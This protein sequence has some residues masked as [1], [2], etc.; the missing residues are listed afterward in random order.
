MAHSS[1]PPVI[2]IMRMAFATL[3]VI[4]PPLAVTWAYKIWFQSPRYKT[5]KRELAWLSQ[6]RQIQINSS[7]G[8]IATY[9]WGDASKPRVFL[10]HGWSGR[11]LQL[12]AFVEP[13]LQAGYSVTS[14]DAPGHG[15]SDGNSTT[16]F[17]VADVLRQIVLDA[18]RPH[19]IISH[20]FG[21]M[22]SAYALHH[23]QLDIHKCIAISCP[24]TPKYL[25]EN[26]VEMFQLNNRVTDGFIAELK[27]E[28]GDDVLDRISADLN[29]QDWFGELLVIHDKDDDI[30]H[31]Q[32]SESLAE[33]AKNSK[34]MYTSSLGHRRI[35]GD[36]EVIGATVNF[37]Q[38]GNHGER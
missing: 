22:V 24:T 2:K 7:H 6:S 5:P 9:H 11:G 14:F 20:S 31:W 19:A 21:G 34:T 23:Y 33:A 30:V 13:L 15:Q 17:Q 1:I 28:F 26:F 29:L 38:A 12:G 35:L 4:A 36:S 27:K 3:G 37:I 32:Y 25:I 16:V 8:R 18:E 10:V